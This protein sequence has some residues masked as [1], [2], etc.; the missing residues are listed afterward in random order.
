MNRSSALRTLA[1]F[2]GLGAI[3]WAGAGYLGSNLLALSVT[4]VIAAFY[5]AGAL[6][7]RKYQQATATLQQALAADDGMPQPASGLG[8]WL[9]RLH[10][11]LRQSVRQRIEGER[12]GLPGPALTPYLTGLLVLLGMLGTFLGMVVTLHGTGT[13]LESATDLSAVRASLAAPVKGLGLAFGTSLAGIAGSAMLGLLSALCRRERLQAAQQ[14]DARI[15]SSLRVFS[16]AHQREESLKLLQQQSQLMPTV[17]DRLQAMMTALEQQSLAMNERLLAG[18]EAFHQKAGAAYA[19]LAASV[20]RSLNESLAESA[21]AAGAV[22]EPV[23]ERTMV[24]IASTFEQGSVSLVQSVSTQLQAAVGEVTSQLG[25]TLGSVTGQLESTLGGVSNKL[26][27]TLGAVSSQLESTLDGVSGKLASTLDSVSGKLESTVDSVSGKLETT[28]GAVSAQLKST[29]G[30]VSTRLDT[31][32][33]G[34][35]TQLDGN[36]GGVSSRLESTLARISTQ[37][38]STL[39][40]V[41]TKLE[42]TL[43]GVSTQLQGSADEV[44]ANWRGALAEHQQ[45]GQALAASTQQALQ[46]AAGSFEAHSASLLQTMDEAHVRQQEALAA[47]DEQRLAAWTESL[48]TMSAA[49][50]QQWHDAGALNLAQQQEICRTLAQTADEMATQSQAQARGTIAEIAQL[51]QAASEA[52]RAAAEVMAQLR[53]KLSDSMERDNSLLEERANI[54]QTLETLLGAINH[55]ATEQRAA[56][57]SLVAGSAEMLQRVGSEFGQKAQAQAQEINEAAA[58]L[59]GSAVDVASLGDA[60]GGAVELFGQANEKMVSQLQRIEAALAK[61]MARSD[62]QL[63][64]YVAQAREVVDLSVRSQK[65]IIEDLQQIAANTPPALAAA[66]EA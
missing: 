1:F 42:A 58:Q 10:P 30:A 33:A 56:I 39:D 36:L 54:L 31:T 50:Q 57:D 47:R 40:G 62:E 19:E 11:S 18:Q 2:V 3:A 32:L 41:S 22:I 23:V 27:A 37:L 43:D 16:L 48:Q 5:L 28:L 63:D 24:G 53:Q 9:E 35:S 6:E 38:E 59:T 65:Q 44:A 4:A 49:L 66:N 20:G 34:V 51:V 13:A 26:D 12:V 7:L 15:G 52:P 46:A 17:V 14:L 64:Y 61:A 8:P 25:T 45:A 29:L 60:F 55:A 21:R